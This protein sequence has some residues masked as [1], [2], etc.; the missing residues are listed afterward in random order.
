MPALFICN[1]A[2]IVAYW[3]SK[4]QPTNGAT[5]TVATTPTPI[6]VD[7]IMHP[8]CGDYP[9]NPRVSHPVLGWGTVTAI[10]S[11]AEVRVRYNQHGVFEWYRLNDLTGWGVQRAAA[12][13]AWVRR[14]VA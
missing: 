6:A 14:V 5:M 9:D 7:R 3:A 10:T 11:A 13:T 2:L 4:Q 1:A 8:E 12:M